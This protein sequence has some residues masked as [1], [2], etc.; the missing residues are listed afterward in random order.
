MK[1]SARTRYSIRALVDLAMHR[2][3]EPVSIRFLAQEL[4][5]SKNYLE[6]LMV[7]L[8][9]KGL[10]VPS[11]GPKGGYSLAKHPGDISL[12]EIFIATEG[13]DALVYCVSCPDSCPH[14]NYCTSR[15]L[16]KLLGEAVVGTLSPITLE[17]MA[18][19]QA[20]KL[21]RSLC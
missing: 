18:K 14:S 1:V 12:S 15:D 16:M 2:A 9:R 5:I 6:N 13:S 19:G 10:V 17:S 7:I 8:K 4:G 11:R 3:E 21:D 20:L